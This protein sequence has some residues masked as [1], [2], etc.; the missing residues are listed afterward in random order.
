MDPQ[1]SHSSIED[2]SDEILLKIF[3]NIH[4][5]CHCDYH[6]ND[7]LDQHC[8]CAL[9][10][11]Y[12][13]L[14]RL[15][16]FQ[17]AATELLYS[18]IEVKHAKDMIIL[19]RTIL[20]HPEL[21]TLIRKL[22]IKFN[23]DIKTVDKQDLLL[24]N[25]HVGLLHLRF[26]QEGQWTCHSEDPTAYGSICA[27]LFLIHAPDIT[28][29]TIDDT[30]GW[31]GQ[32]IKGSL[33]STW[34]TTFDPTA[35]Q[36]VSRPTPMTHNL[37]TLCMQQGDY[38]LMQM[39]L[40]FRLRSLR[41]V[42]LVN[43]TQL[44]YQTNWHWE[45]GEG[46]SSVRTL[47]L[48]DCLVHPKLVAM[49]VKACKVLEE[50]SYSL[51]PYHAPGKL[52]LASMWTALRNH[53]HCIKR[54]E[55]FTYHSV[56]C[57]PLANEFLDYT[58]LEVLRLDTDLICSH[59][60]TLPD[61]SS[62]FPACLKKLRIDMTMALLREDVDDPNGPLWSLIGHKDTVFPSLKCLEFGFWDQEDPWEVAVPFKNPILLNEFRERG[63]TVFLCDVYSEPCF[64][65]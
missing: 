52:D 19:L 13:S 23:L 21:G 40:L 46:L 37:T 34:T 56:S 59:E 53:K 49:L 12:A 58:S 31:V 60:E 14:C 35:F 10:N 54:I 22:K 43:W 39:P 65:W 20:L 28:E 29:L 25:E 61:L 2:L 11:D 16:P 33:R 17:R 1:P 64:D 6:D 30:N 63:I 32:Y 4:H 47:N 51:S 8:E 62:V 55:F 9:R 27:A 18:S 15:Q 24:F 41:H 3:R 48:P 7:A 50:F 44:E 45:T 36:S 38:I 5:E 57:D 26:T 42:K